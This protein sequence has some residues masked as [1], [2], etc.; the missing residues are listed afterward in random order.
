[1]NRLLALFLL[2]AFLSFGFQRSDAG[3][4]KDLCNYSGLSTAE[5]FTT[6]SSWVAFF[7]SKAGRALVNKKIKKLKK[8]IKELAEED[9]SVKFKERKK[10]LENLEKFLEES[11]KALRYTKVVS[12]ATSA[13][14]TMLLFRKTLG[15]SAGMNP[16][17]KKIMSIIPIACI[18]LL[19]GVGAV[20]FFH[21]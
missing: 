15:V 1:M 4:I 19:C 9:S 11:S 2:T 7:G 5:G 8:T 21:F 14:S 17:Y 3:L 6:L 13:V 16:K 20:E 18:G 12:F 10:D